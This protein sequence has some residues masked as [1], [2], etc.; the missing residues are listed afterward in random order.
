MEWEGPEPNDVE[1]L[2]IK[3]WLNPV[4]SA[5]QRKE[6][7]TWRLEIYAMT[8]HLPQGVG[9]DFDGL[10][11][12]ISEP[13]DVAATTNTAGEVT[14]DYSLRSARPQPKLISP[15]PSVFDPQGK[16]PTTLF[17]VYAL[18]ADGSAAGNVALGV[19]DAETSFTS[20]G[21]TLHRRRFTI[22]T[23]EL[24]GGFWDEDNT[25]RGVPHLVIENG[26]YSAA[27]ITFSSG[28]LFDLGAAPTG[29]VELIGITQTPPGTSVTLEVRNDADSGWVAFTNGQF[30]EAD[31]GFSSPQSKKMRATL[32][33]NGAGNLTPT[34][35]KLGRQAI[36]R[37][38]FSRVALIQGY[39]Q[40]FSPENHKV[41]IPRPRLVA[42]KDGPRD[43][44][45]KIEKLM[46]EN[47]INDI[48][49]RWMVGDPALP[50]SKWTHMDDFLV[51]DSTPRQPVI[52]LQL[53]G[54]CALLKDLAPPFSPGTNY[55]PD[56]THSIGTWTDL[57]GGSTNIHLNI[58][59]TT[60]DE[61]DGIRS[62]TSPA[63]A[64]YIWT[65]PTPTDLAGRRIF[66]DVFYGKDTTGG[67]QI[68]A[69]FRVYNAGAQVMET[70]VQVDV[71]V[72][73][74]QKSFELSETQIQLLTDLPNLRASVIANAPTPG[75]GRRLHLY[76]ARIRSGG[77]REVVTYTSQTLKAVYDDFIANR[78]AIPANLR[79]P[80]VENTTTT[81]SKQVTGLRKRVN[82]KDVVAKTELEAIAFLADG[83]VGSSEGKIRFF[84]LRPGGPVRAVFRSR[85]IQIGEVSPGHERRLPEYFVPY[86]WDATKE[87]FKD[88]ARG[89]HTQSILKIGTVGLGPPTWL[90]EE[91]AK[92]IDTDALGE[93][94]A[95]RVVDRLG[96]GEMLWSFASV[97][98]YH[99]LEVGDVV[100]VETD[101]FVSRD[102][103]I[104][105]EV[106]GQRFAVGPLQRV[107]AGRFFTVHPRGYADIISESQL[108]RRA[109]FNIP[110]V[111]HMQLNIT[112]AA[113]VATSIGTYGA[114]AVRVATS[115]SADPSEAT[116]RAA[117]LV[118]LDDA[119]NV[120]IDLG[121]LSPNQT[122][123]VAAF[124]YDGSDGS[125]Q[126]SDIKRSQITN[127]PIRKRIIRTNSTTFMVP[128]DWNNTNNTIE[129][130]GGGGGGGGGVTNTRGGGG[131][132]GG[133][134]RRLSNQSLTPGA[135][136]SYAIGAAGTGGAAG[137]NN[138]TAGG[139]TTWNAGAVTAV[140]G[141]AG[142]GSSPPTG[143]AGGTGG[144]GGGTSFAGGA[145]GTG[146]TPAGAAGG[147]GG[148]GAGG[149][150]AV[151]GTGGNGSAGAGGTGGNG[152]A[153]FGG[154]GQATVG[155]SGSIWSPTD[156]AGG[157]AN[158][159]GPPTPTAGGTGGQW[160]AGGGGGGA[161][162]GSQSGGG[163]GQGGVLVIT[164]YSSA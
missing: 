41:E 128:A 47:F 52:E 129:L 122:M 106:R 139:N 70:A 75:T 108:A 163:N 114:R 8:G 45:S 74:V 79:G 162:V 103:N 91:I 101:L 94:I 135:T 155:G 38:D 69:K 109:G 111:E 1:I 81:V 27:T 43:F 61:T 144:G 145:G 9:G 33:P 7:V 21:Q 3:L 78:L 142:L 159:G 30:E 141:G 93:G 28:N 125:G 19:N 154:T 96:T 11:T 134:Y 72:V 133:E 88:E 36:R 100:A 48:R 65:E 25:P 35:R 148:G 97:D 146:A 136:I 117:A 42:V 12:P 20:G 34:L 89:F 90:D 132:G 140:G 102:P 53:V 64:E 147:G 153:D 54:L 57:A 37:I 59:E 62:V 67:E 118:L 44:S 119:G 71:G 160:G 63:N 113:T 76:W 32:T 158:G 6:V 120:T 150:T 39:E 31:L 46:A 116:T 51:L 92:W 131:G 82:D 157:G 26:T 56:G 149:T 87:E 29:D 86:R 84:D 16:P 126:E 2:R 121:A 13:L 161:S 127:Q 164:Y 17:I 58:D 85:R 152:G 68:D 98:R 95:R 66:L 99:E 60:P 15:L 156:G 130:I 105:Q 80:G 4:V 73:P 49:F 14:F 23:S 77:R 143:G 112:S 22:K 10:Y 137:A 5:A 124:A 123:Y 83:A 138:G 110:V 151:G 104:N 50:R 18:A 40:A 115:T 107:G 24:L 55:A